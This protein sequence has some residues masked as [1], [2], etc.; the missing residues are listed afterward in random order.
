MSSKH[1]PILG[2]DGGGD[3][4]GNTERNIDFDVKIK[5]NVCLTCRARARSVVSVEVDRTWHGWRAIA[6]LVSVV[7]FGEDHSPV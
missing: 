2:P 5:G 1:S 6:G 4:A 7:A 3:G